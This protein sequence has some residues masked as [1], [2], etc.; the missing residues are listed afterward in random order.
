MLPITF[1]IDLRRDFKQFN[2]NLNKVHNRI[3]DKLLQLFGAMQTDDQYSLNSKSNKLSHPD[4][5]R[6]HIFHNIIHILANIRALAIQNT[7][8][9]AI[10]IKAEQV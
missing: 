5:D 7:F 4:I 1:H 3:P 10:F 9:P 6:A 8:N 2:R